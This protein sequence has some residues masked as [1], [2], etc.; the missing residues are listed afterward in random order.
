MASPDFRAA[1]ERH[2][3]DGVL[4]SEQ[5]RLPGADHF[6]GIAAECAIKAAL[7]AACVLKLDARGMPN[8]PFDQHCPGIWNEYAIAHGGHAS[9][10]R[11]PLPQ[12]NPFL[13]TWQITDR[14][15][16]GGAVNS[17]ALAAHR[18]G[19]L[20]ALNIMQAFTSGESN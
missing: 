4:L 19:A 12:N 9:L 5:G 18:F 2:Y 11:L 15:K 20:V 8:K 1:A 14:Y 6:F 3:E 13:G 16:E 10:S 17:N 7:E